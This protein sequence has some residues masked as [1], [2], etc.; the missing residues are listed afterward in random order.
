MPTCERQSQNFTSSTKRIP[1]RI[2]AANPRLKY[3][4]LQFVCKFGREPRKRDTVRKRKTKS[5]QCG[6]PFQIMLQL[7]VNNQHL[8]VIKVNEEHNHLIT[9]EHLPKQ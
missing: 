7:S 8:K 1:K 3:H 6:C 5:F 4:I 2:A 9:N